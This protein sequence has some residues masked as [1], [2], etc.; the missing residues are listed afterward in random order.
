MYYQDDGGTFWVF[1]ILTNIYAAMGFFIWFH[2][3][4]QKHPY[5]LYAYGIILGSIAAYYKIVPVLAL[6]GWWAELFYGVNNINVITAVLRNYDIGVTE[7]GKRL[8][9]AYLIYLDYDFLSR[10]SCSFFI[11][12]QVI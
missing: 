10:F 7:G 11:A 5:R 4:L 8:N 12:Y 2:P 1:F 3:N 6:N 9:D